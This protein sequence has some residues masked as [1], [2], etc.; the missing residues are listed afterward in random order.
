[1]NDYQKYSSLTIYSTNPK[2]QKT[3]ILAE[4]QTILGCNPNK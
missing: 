2:R 1:M 4:V 3:V